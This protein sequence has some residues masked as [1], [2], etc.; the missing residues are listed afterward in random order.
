MA[1]TPRGRYEGKVSIVVGP[2]KTATTFV[3]DVLERHPDVSLPQGIKETF[4]FDRYY[5]NGVDWY[6]GRFDLSGP[7]PHLVEVATSYFAEPEAIARIAATFPAARIVICVRDPVERAISHYEHLRRYGYCKG[8]IADVLS[9]DA[10]FVTASRYSVFCPM[11][12]E[13][14]GPAH[15]NVLDMN[16]LR[17]APA[18]FVDSVFRAVGVTP[19]A[20]PDEVLA[21]RSNVAREPGFYPLARLATA[22]S[23]QFKRRGWYGVLERLRAS[24]LHRLVYG[25]ARSEG[26][27][28]VPAGARARLE[29][30]LGP[31]RVF[32]ARRYGISAARGAQPGQQADAALVP[33][34]S[35]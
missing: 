25:R 22:V 10:P 7:D 20:L 19:V 17:R 11:W 5:D 12:E 32:L 18:D 4:F 6:L 9:E 8:P 29:A 13:A 16:L 1:K 3:H 35:A 30:M 23:N 26:R 28:R 34:R 24:P 2:E 31:E 33:D 14:F 27:A 21:R 15:V